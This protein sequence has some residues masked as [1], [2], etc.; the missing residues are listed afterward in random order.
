MD[1]LERKITVYTK[2]NC[3]QCIM[4][5]QELTRHGLTY[6]EINV[7]EQP[8]ALEELIERNLRSMPVV[9]VDGNWNNAFG[10]FQPDRLAELKEVAE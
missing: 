6:K 9:V 5:K 7:D 8:A 10:G 1:I 3:I 2:N 4:T